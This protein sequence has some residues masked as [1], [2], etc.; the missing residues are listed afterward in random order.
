MKRG[1]VIIDEMILT[2]LDKGVLPENC[3][4]YRALEFVL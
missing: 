2:N 3:G 1:E 4:F